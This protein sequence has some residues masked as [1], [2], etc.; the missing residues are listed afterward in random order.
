MYQVLKEGMTFFVNEEEK[1]KR[2][3]ED[4]C[5]V[6]SVDKLRINEEGELEKDEHDLEVSGTGVS[7]ELP[8]PE[9]HTIG[10]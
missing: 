8:Q 10:G 5:D 4:G 7:E 9:A 3:A 1:A 6:F 2:Y